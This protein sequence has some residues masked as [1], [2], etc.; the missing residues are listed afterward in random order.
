MSTYHI[1]KERAVFAL[2]EALNTRVY[3]PLSKQ[4][5]LRLL[6]LSDDWLNMLTTNKQS[7]LVHIGLPGMRVEHLEQYRAEQ[8]VDMLIAVRA[9][10]WVY[11]GKGQMWRE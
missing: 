6:Q 1:G 7:S 2:A 8:G 11:S 10:G 5:V 4:R 9:T 3:A